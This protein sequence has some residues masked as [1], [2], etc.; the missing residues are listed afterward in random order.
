MSDLAALA[1]NNLAVTNVYLG[2]IKEASNALDRMMKQNP[3]K[4]N[5]NEFLIQNLSVLYGSETP[6]SLGK[7]ILLLEHVA[8]YKGDAFSTTSLRL[9]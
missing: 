5:T 4:K 7:K 6:K 3:V 9:T 8:K 2:K 1:C